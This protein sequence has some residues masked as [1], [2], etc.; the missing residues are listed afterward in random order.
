MSNKC[1]EQSIYF[2]YM[3]KYFYLEITRRNLSIRVIRIKGMNTHQYTLMLSLIL[4]L[5]ITIIAYFG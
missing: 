4:L 3:K 5:L 2:Q 1:D